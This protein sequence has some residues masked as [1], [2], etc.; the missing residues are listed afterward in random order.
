MQKVLISCFTHDASLYIKA[1]QKFHIQAD[2]S[3]SPEDAD[4]FDGLLLPGG[5]DISPVFYHRKNRG[6]NNICISEDIV[7]LLMFHRF[8]EQQ[9]PILGICKGMQVINVALGGTLIQALPT[10]NS[11]AWHNGDRYHPTTISS[12]S[13][14][15]SLYGTYMVTGSSH[16]QAVSTLGNGLKP[17]QHAHDGV[18]EGIEHESLPILGL[19]WHPERLC[20]IQ[21]PSATSPSCNKPLPT[22]VG[23]GL[24]I[25]EWFASQL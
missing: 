21:T 25:F 16:H 2:L 24:C 18:I 6:S 8:M 1:L 10:V 11:H 12:N 5:G 15:S 7:Q 13:I 20:G 14:L 23:N 22:N 3:G 4:D 19:Q 17:V 9:K